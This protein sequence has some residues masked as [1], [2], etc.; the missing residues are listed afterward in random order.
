MPGKKNG[1]S[2][3]LNSHSISIWII[4]K[5]QIIYCDDIICAISY[6]SAPLLKGTIDDL[7]A[8]YFNEKTNNFLLPFILVTS[9]FFFWGFIHNL[10]PILIPHLRRAFSLNTVQAS[11]VDSAVYFG[12]FFMAIPAG[13][14]MRKYGYKTG[15]LMGLALFSVGCF[16]FVPAAD[17]MQYALFLGALF[18]VACGLAILETAANPYAT[19]L[20]PPETATQR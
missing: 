13:F 18:I 10:D 4:I 16:M 8:N 17:T 5:R 11:L 3:S 6:L 12:Y 15:I 1:G 7:P 9:L 19:I 2:I 14:I 20:G